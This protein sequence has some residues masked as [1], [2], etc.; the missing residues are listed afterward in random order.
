MGLGGK[1]KPMATETLLGGRYRLDHVAGHGGMATVFA[2]YDTVLERTVAIKLLQRRHD[3]S[4]VLHARF[5]REALVE[6]K[7]AHPNVV[8]VHDVGFHEDGRPYIVM[9]FVDGQPLQKLIAEGPLPSARVA[10]LGVSLARALAAAHDLG[11]V[12]RD[13]KPANILIDGQGL[14]HLTDFGLAR[15]TDD[16]DL[17]MHGG[18]VG[19]ANYVAPE[20]A[21]YGTSTPQGDLYSLGAVLY[22][23]LAGVPPFE[24]SGA[25]DVALRRFEEDPPDLL[26]AVPDVDPELAALVHALLAREPASR[27]PDAATVVERLT[28]I[29]ARLRLAVPAAAA[30]VSPASPAAGAVLPTIPMPNPSMLPTE[31]WPSADPAG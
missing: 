24:G 12:H 27:P 25:I 14:P 22:H 17:T 7:L 9:D 13:V 23:A 3:A 21:R 5:R 29:A 4:G 10:V 26:A 8:A 31:T 30:A 19:T 15:M 1:L 2:A 20:Q 18:L 11:I 28:D 6:A 16:E